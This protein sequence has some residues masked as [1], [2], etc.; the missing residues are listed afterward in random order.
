ML[1]NRLSVDSGSMEHLTIVGHISNL[2]L[3]AS[4]ATERNKILSGC[5]QPDH[6]RWLSA[7]KG[8]IEYIP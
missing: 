6:L 5:Q 7:G 4:G 2:C 1:Y 3:R 8:F